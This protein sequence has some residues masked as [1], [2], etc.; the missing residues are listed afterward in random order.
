ME[1]NVKHCFEN[2][3]RTVL[4]ICVSCSIYLFNVN[5]SF[6]FQTGM[7]KNLVKSAPSLVCTNAAKHKFKVVQTCMVQIL[8]ELAFFQLWYKHPQ[9]AFNSWKYMINKLKSVECFEL[10]TKENLPY[11]LVDEVKAA[12]NCFNRASLW[13]LLSCHF[14]I[15]LQH[16]SKFYRGNTILRTPVVSLASYW[17]GASRAS[18]ILTVVNTD[19]LCVFNMQ[20]KSICHSLSQPILG[21]H[22]KAGGRCCIVL[23]KI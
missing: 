19:V 1:I 6:I 20:V 13:L 14:V 5:P 23:Q 4:Y 15:W 2:L 11:N 21:S 16:L 18:S 12:R 10:F 9:C 8:H 17:L 22:I 7:T 3:K